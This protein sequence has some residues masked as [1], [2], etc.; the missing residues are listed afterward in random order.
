VDKKVRNLRK[1]E[2]KKVIIAFLDYL[3]RIK[4]NEKPLVLQTTA[5]IINTNPDLSIEEIQQTLA[6]KD[7]T[8]LDFFRQL[9]IRGGHRVLKELF[10]D[11]EILNLPTVS[12][13]ETGNVIKMVY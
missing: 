13:E 2:N 1:N 10:P 3:K 6:I 8:K 4:I 5:N 11:E 7:K 12:F 9:Y